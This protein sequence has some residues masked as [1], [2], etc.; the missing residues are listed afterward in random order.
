MLLP[1]LDLNT[2]CWDPRG[3]GMGRKE[4]LTRR[5]ETT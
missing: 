2:H 4:A 5:K 3:M 1:S